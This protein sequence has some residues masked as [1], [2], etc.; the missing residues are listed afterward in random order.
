MEFGVLRVS[1]CV[2]SSQ[3]PTAWVKSLLVIWVSFLPAVTRPTFGGQAHLLGGWIE[4]DLRRRQLGRRA[5]G[6]ASGIL[7]TMGW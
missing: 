4:E 5:L 6:K 7:E 1:V 3:L 2:C